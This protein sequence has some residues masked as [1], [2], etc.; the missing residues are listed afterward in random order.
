MKAITFII[1]ALINI[2]FGFGLFFMLIVSL[3]GFTGKEAESG[4]ILFIVWT[5]L[6]ALLA[7]ALSFLC[8]GYFINKKSLHPALAAFLATAIFA[9]VGAASDI[10]GFFTAVFLTSAM[11]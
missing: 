1:T 8:A 9:V 6:T 7:G 4:L 3:N 10:V 11:R 2:G 5:G